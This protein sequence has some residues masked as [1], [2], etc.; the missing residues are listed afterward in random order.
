MARRACESQVPDYLNAI[1]TQ[2][3]GFADPTD[4]NG[5]SIL[6]PDKIKGVIA[7]FAWKIKGL[8]KV[9]LMK[10]MWYTDVVSFLRHGHSMT[11]L[12]YRHMPYGALPIGADE[13]VKIAPVRVEE[14]EIDDH[15]IIYIKPRNDQLWRE[16][17]K[18]L[19]NDDIEVLLDVFHQLGH[20]K[21]LELSEIM[22][23]E[24]AY[25]NTKHF[26]IIPFSMAK[27]IKAVNGQSVPTSKS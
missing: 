10:L 25:V 3:Q 15:T 16:F 22:H 17:M 21:G 18:H 8:A 11:G 13:I 9:R 2:Y 12:V 26:D 5:E 19:T 4:E 20:Y 27:D 1:Q 6:N 24:N 23:R 14:V 7:W